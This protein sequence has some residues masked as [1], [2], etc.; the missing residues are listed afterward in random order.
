LLDHPGEQVTEGVPEQAVLPP[1]PQL[2]AQAR[3]GGQV[4]YDC[5]PTRAE[6]FAAHKE[7][8]DWFAWF[9]VRKRSADTSESTAWPNWIEERE[10]YWLETIERRGH[11]LPQG[12]Y[13]SGEWHYE[14]RAKPAKVK[15]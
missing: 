2:Q 14:Y 3:E 12:W 9:P 11:Y 10:C 4:K 6:L 1:P 8:H 7:W 5:G 13:G 15:P